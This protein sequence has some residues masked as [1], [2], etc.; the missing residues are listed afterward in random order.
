[1]DFPAD[2]GCASLTD[3]TETPPAAC[4]DGVDND[5]DG[6]ADLADPGCANASDTSE[7]SASLIC[8][9]GLDNDSDG[10]VDFPE[11]AGC[12]SVADAFEEVD[13]T[14]GGA[15]FIDA[16]T[17]V[18]Q[19]SV[20][21]RDGPAGAGPA[22][23]E[24]RVGGVVDGNLSASGSVAVMISAGNLMGGF[25]GEG[26]TKL[27]VEGGSVE[28]GM[29]LYDDASAT[30]RAGR[31]F[32]DLYA[33]DRSIIEIHGTN[34]DRPL[35]DLDEKIGRVSGVLLDGT[36]VTVDF[37]RALSAKI[38]LIPE[39]DALLVAVAALATLAGLRRAGR[40]RT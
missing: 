28:S 24:L 40:P 14:D 27:E 20:I 31:I 34:F 25:V 3:P 15:Q 2:S 12:E 7:K 13:F 39:P 37:E 18:P 9:D 35:G 1:M 32:G 5:G 23:L 10:S 38:R 19:E 29:T 26:V 8:D 17:S 16:A 4:A 33:W 11:D 30:L 36:P 21:V 6:G 22:S